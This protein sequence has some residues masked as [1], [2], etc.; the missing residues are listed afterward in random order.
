MS[1]DP[2]LEADPTA[3]DNAGSQEQV[4]QPQP[5]TQPAGRTYTDAD[6]ASFRRSQQAEWDRREARIRSEFEQRYVPREQ[7]KPT[8]PFGEL[9]DPTVTPKFEAALEAYLSTRLAP[10][11]QNQEDLSFSRDEAEIRAKYKDYGPN[12]A[13]ILN[14]A[15]QNEIVNLD[16]AY[17]AWKY[18]ELSKI[19]PEKIGRDAV[20]KHVNRKAAQSAGTPSVE[21]RGGGAPSSK[22]NLKTREEMD[23]AVEAMLR[24]AN[25]NSA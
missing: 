3:G 23:E 5:V 24:S 4:Q 7:P 14:F 22:Q 2:N 13:D 19:D 1:F 17:R 10:F 20:A 21:G 15:V 16:A 25:E 9:L 8:S 6:M 12:R 11:Q 18:D